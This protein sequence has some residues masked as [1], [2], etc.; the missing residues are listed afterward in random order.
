[1]AAALG[2]SRRDA[3][4]SGSVGGRH[5]SESV[6]TLDKGQM[7]V[8][9][10][11][12]RHGEVAGDVAVDN[13]KGSTGHNL[14]AGGT[15]ACVERAPCIVSHLELCSGGDVDGAGNPGV[16]LRTGHE[17]VLGDSTPVGSFGEAAAEIDVDRNARYPDSEVVGGH[18]LEGHHIGE[19][20]GGL[21][22]NAD[23]G[24]QTH[25]ESLVREGQ[26]GV[27]LHTR[28]LLEGGGNVGVQGVDLAAVI[29]ILLDFLELAK[30]SV[31]EHCTR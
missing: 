6:D 5:H 13:H 11:G 21:L 2:G 9:V 23:V 24:A 4:K 19:E 22:L 30:S 26:V 15:S 31:R 16:L 14:V 27:V 12:H 3:G 8:T 29:E 1:M 25:V 28:E 20:L 10:E 7:G 17:L 18:A